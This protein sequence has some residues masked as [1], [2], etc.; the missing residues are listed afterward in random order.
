MINTK[1]TATPKPKAVLTVLDTAKYEHMPKKK[2]KIMFSMNTL[3]MKML[4]SSPMANYFS[5][6]SLNLLRCTQ[7]IM[8]TTIKAMGGNNIIPLLL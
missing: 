6:R 1:V 3:L 2:A 4:I 7:I 5:M 8:A